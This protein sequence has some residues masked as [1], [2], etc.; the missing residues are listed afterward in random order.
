MRH[1]GS[2]TRRYGDYGHM[3]QNN[4]STRGGGNSSSKGAPEVIVHNSDHT[5]ENHERDS[6]FSQ[7]VNHLR[8]PPAV[9]RTSSGSKL[10]SAANPNRADIPPSRRKA[11]YDPVSLSRNCSLLGAYL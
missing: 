7:G 2:S 11:S 4:S 8:S 10:S 5:Q 6:H 9:D 1:P 3:P